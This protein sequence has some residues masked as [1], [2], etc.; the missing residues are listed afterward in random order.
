MALPYVRYNSS[1]GSNTAASG[2]G[3]STALTGGTAT[4]A[5]TTVT[6]PALTDLTNVATDGS[7]CIWVNSSGANRKLS[8]ITNKAG[9]GGATPTVTT[10]D[11]LAVAAVSWAIGGKR[12]H[13]ENSTS[14]VDVLD[15]KAGW[16]FHFEGTGT[17]DQSTAWV[18]VAGDTTN[19]GI[20]VRGDSASTRATLRQTGNLR[21]LDQFEFGKVM[22]LKATT[23]N[24]TNTATGLI[25]GVSNNGYSM[26]IRDCVMDTLNRG[27]LLDT[28]SGV[29]ISGCEIK[30]CTGSGIHFA[31]GA[32]N[33]GVHIDG[34]KITDC[35]TADT[36]GEAG[37]SFNGSAT[38]ALLITNSEVVSN[39]R[40]NVFWDGLGALALLNCVVYD[41]K[42]TGGH[43]VRVSANSTRASFSMFNS[44]L[45]GNAGYGL[46][47]P[48]GFDP[49][50]NNGIDFNAFGSNT[51]GA[52][53]NTTAG[54]SDVTLSADP[55]TN[56]ASDDFS[57]NAT[58]GGGAACKA[59]GYPT[60]FP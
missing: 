57:L 15:G 24:G 27:M 2:A 19:G 54:G 26:E 40:E 17:Y 22:Y 6:L 32:A 33:T 16:T 39:K 13:G 37:I 25:R 47:C 1:T 3:P 53:N 4:S 10:E 58:A 12:L 9:S 60:A 14:R 35:N 7:H 29:V 45:Y 41:G 11:T 23:N 42:G 38:S 48:S 44:I 8:K 55:F 36:A 28:C 31:S 5:G 52:R 49:I 46:N 30:N 50:A 34:C 59:V 56:G 51:S 18:P 21:H 20:T 43:G